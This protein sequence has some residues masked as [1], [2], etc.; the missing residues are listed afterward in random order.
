MQEGADPAGWWV[1]VR[2]YS[3]AGIRTELQ[4]AARDYLG[5]AVR[6]GSKVHLPKI[7]HW[8]GKDFGADAGQLLQWVADHMPEERV[9]TP[10]PLLH[11]STTLVSLLTFQNCGMSLTRTGQYTSHW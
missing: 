6:V 8:Y 2:V 5:A 9:T 4:V 11:Y 3:A 7:L 10:T 1:Q